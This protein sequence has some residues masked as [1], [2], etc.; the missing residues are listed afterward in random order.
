MKRRNSVRD[1]IIDVALSESYC[2]MCGN[3]FAATENRRQQGVTLASCSNTP[4]PYSSTADN[5]VTGVAMRLEESGKAMTFA[6]KVMKGLLRRANNARAGLMPSQDDKGTSSITA[7][8][9]S[10]PVDNKRTATGVSSPVDNIGTATGVSS[11][12][13]SNTTA[14]DP[15]ALENLARIFVDQYGNPDLLG[16][17]EKDQAYQAKWTSLRRDRVTA[18]QVISLYKRFSGQWTMPDGDEA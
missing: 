17:L 13:D 6:T 4:A 14:L 7:T 16:C 8:G 3:S 2:L 11:P 12:V 15:E 9:V 1:A 18:E 10:S 5:V